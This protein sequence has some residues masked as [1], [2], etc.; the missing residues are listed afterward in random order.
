MKADANPIHIFLDGGLHDHFRRLVQPGVDDLDPGVAE[1][2]ADHFDPAVMTIKAHLGG[3]HAD[4]ANSCL[5]HDGYEFSPAP[6][7]GY[8][9]NSYG[10]GRN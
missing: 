7:E 5:A 3:E 6:F 4:L 2:S 9:P 1:R 10:F 8:D